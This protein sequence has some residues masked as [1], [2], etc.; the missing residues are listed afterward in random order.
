MNKKQKQAFTDYMAEASPEALI[1]DGFDD[2]IIGVAERC[3]H[4]PLVIY[5][6]A[7]CI[8]I[9]VDEGMDHGEA[10]DHFGYNVSGAWLGEG[11]PMFMTSIEDITYYCEE[12]DE[13]F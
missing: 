8:N 11:T 9:L 3:G 1:A 5:D 13:N 10:I 12:T 6:I 4:P 7:K 2:A